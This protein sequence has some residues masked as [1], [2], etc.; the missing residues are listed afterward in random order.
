MQ[1]LYQLSYNP[2]VPTHFIYFYIK[3]QIILRQKTKN[4]P[5]RGMYYSL[6]LFISSIFFLKSETENIPKLREASTI[7][8]TF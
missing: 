6:V 4:P 8:F 1:V 3:S 2:G 5:K 7:F